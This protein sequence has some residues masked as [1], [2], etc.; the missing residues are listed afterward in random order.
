MARLHDAH[1][2]DI[3]III[4]SFMQLYLESLPECLAGAWRVQVSAF[5][6]VAC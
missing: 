4:N 1:G 5:N 6:F 3:T 2:W